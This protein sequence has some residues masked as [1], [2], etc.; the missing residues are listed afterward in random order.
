MGT[1]QYDLDSGCRRSSRAYAP[2]SALRLGYRL[3]AFAACSGATTAD[4]LSKQI[5]RVSSTTGYVTIS[6]GGDDANFVGVVYACLVKRTTCARNVNGAK[7]TIQNQL[8]KRLDAVYGAI[9][10]RDPSA[11]VVVVGYPHLFK[12]TCGGLNPSAQIR[13]GSTRPPTFST[14]SS[15]A[16]RRRRTS[17][18]S[19]RAPGS[20][21]T[22][23]AATLRGSTA[24]P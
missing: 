5:G 21:A 15:H 7:A 9:Q 11:V 23:S 12:G 24:P 19:T 20:S 16:Q 18:S 6:V 8:P 1:Y 17:G 13:T 4:V 14:V 3:T 10:L 22:R 2:I